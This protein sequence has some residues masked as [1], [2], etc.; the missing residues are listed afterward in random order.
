MSVLT[1]AFARR[2]SS[3][4]SFFFLRCRATRAVASSGGRPLMRE[5]ARRV[6]V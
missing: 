1:R 3:S 6:G 4:A 5:G 2:A